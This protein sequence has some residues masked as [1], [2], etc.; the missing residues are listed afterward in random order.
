MRDLLWISLPGQI[1]D[2]AIVLSQLLKLLSVLLD[3]RCVDTNVVTALR[4]R[5][6]LDKLCNDQRVLIRELAVAIVNDKLPKA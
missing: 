4:M 5:E 3:T 6:V 1:V 2:S